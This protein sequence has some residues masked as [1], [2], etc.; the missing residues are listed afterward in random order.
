MISRVWHGWTTP[1]N[2]DTYERLLLDDVLP[3]IRAKNIP[4]YRGAHVMRRD[5]DQEVEFVTI[6][7][8]DSLESLTAFMGDDYER[9]YVPDAAR[10][11]LARFDARSQ[12]YDLIQAP[13]EAVDP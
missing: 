2:A 4:G 5:A 9:A 6:M 3:G 7:W 10:A 8:L 11:V 1:D 13:S 12:H